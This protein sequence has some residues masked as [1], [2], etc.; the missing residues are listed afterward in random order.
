LLSKKHEQNVE[1]DNIWTAAQAA[2]QTNNA[3]INST[4]ERVE[5]PIT[6]KHRSR[7]KSLL[8]LFKQLASQWKSDFKFCSVQ[9]QEWEELG[10]TLP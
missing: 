8:G 4:L 2:I 6:E 7:H 9:H 3:L 10:C 5:I 1:A